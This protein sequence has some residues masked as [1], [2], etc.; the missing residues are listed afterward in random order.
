MAG[1]T[2]IYTIARRNAVATLLSMPIIMWVIPLFLS[3]KGYS[4]DAI[5]GIMMPL[6]VILLIVG[7]GGSLLLVCPNCRKSLFM[8]GP[9][10]VPWPARTCSECQ[11]DLTR[12]DRKGA[13]V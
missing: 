10:S 6:M 11:T 7:G 3:G 13:P 4:F 12:I 9:F 8:R 1:S 5:S 2:S